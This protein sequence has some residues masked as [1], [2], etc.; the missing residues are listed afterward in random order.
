MKTILLVA[1]FFL[2]FGLVQS[3]QA[4]ALRQEVSFSVSSWVLSGGRVY[5][6]CS[7]ARTETSEMIQKLGGTNV[8]VFCTGG[9]NPLNIDLSTDAE[10]TAYFD[11]PA[12]TGTTSS[13]RFQD[14][15]GCHLA[16]EIFS[17][18]RAKFNIQSVQG[19]TH[20]FDPNESYVFIVQVTR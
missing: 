13:V 5:V 15:S 11:L 19:L 14:F 8:Q 7:L 18:V 2:S 17:G 6:A 4:A 16:S 20:C 9:L 12:P 10:L 1:V 3:A